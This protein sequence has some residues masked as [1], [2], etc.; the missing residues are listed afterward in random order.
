MVKDRIISVILLLFLFAELLTAQNAVNI[1]GIAPG[2][3]GKKI[4][5]VVYDD[6]V[7]GIHRNL[8]GTVADTG[9]RFSISTSISS[10]C[11]ALL[12][13][14]DFIAELYL[15][16]SKHYFLEIDPEN[17][18]NIIET[19]ASMFQTKTLTVNFPE[20]GNMEL[21]LLVYDFNILYSDFVELNFRKLYQRSDKGALDTFKLMLKNRYEGVENP[22][23]NDIVAYR[24]AAL[25]FIS[26]R[27]GKEEVVKRYFNPEAIKYDNPGYM[28]F[29]ITFFEG[30]ATMASA[31]IKQRELYD[32][33]NIHR[34]YLS[35]FNALG[36]DSL[37]QN[38]LLRELV[39]LVTLKNMYYTQGYNRNGIL[40]ILSEISEQSKIKKHKVIAANLIKLFM[41]LQPG[42]KAPPFSLKDDK[43]DFHNLSEYKGRYV[44]LTF[45]ATWCTSCEA[46]FELIKTVNEKYKDKI[47]FVSI[48]ADRHF[49][50]MQYFLKSRSFPW[51]FLH[52]NGDYELL[53][54]Y[55]IKAVPFYVLIDPEGNIKEYPAK[56]PIY[57][58]DSYFDKLLSSGK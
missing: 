18:D 48:S 55:K 25:E 57:N 24:L 11:M 49:M 40:A 1:S 12:Y 42:T 52:F 50:Q 44:Y 36:S 38:D 16:P 28:E 58:L 26:R 22:F 32:A 33:V 10:T 2:A 23:F 15:E 43:G 34:N 41:R 6:Q 37:L 30:Y 53:E 39:M 9:S 8:A 5:L 17:Y 51:T 45:W 19:S 31:Q 29:F 54:N 3:A 21:N 47:V 46:E 27:I 14:D 56:N 7:S 35:L 20:A 13:I 4:R